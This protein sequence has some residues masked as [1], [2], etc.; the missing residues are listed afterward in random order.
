MANSEKTIEKR[1]ISLQDSDLWSNLIYNNS[2]L[3]NEISQNI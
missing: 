1:I 2:V 3:V